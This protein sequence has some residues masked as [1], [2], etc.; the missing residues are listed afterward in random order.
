MSVEFLIWGTQGLAQ[1]SILCHLHTGNKKV[2]TNCSLHAY[3]FASC[4]PWRVPAEITWKWFGA[5]IPWALSLWP[6]KV[7]Q[8]LSKLEITF[9]WFVE[10][11]NVKQECYSLGDVY[12]FPPLG[13]QMKSRLLLSLCFYLPCQ[14]TQQSK[15]RVRG[16]CRGQ[17]YTACKELTKAACVCPEV[18]R[19]P[20]WVSN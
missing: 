7:E 10:I 15:C 17:G 8:F 19:I 14:G 16:L 6:S 4:Y 3:H 20:L 12:R 1:R 9:V 5:Y 13:L 2:F 18:T 11:Q